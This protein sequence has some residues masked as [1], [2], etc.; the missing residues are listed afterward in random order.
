MY[1]LCEA[2]L[3]GFEVRIRCARCGREFFNRPTCP[4]CGWDPSKKSTSQGL[5][6]TLSFIRSSR[7]AGLLFSFAHSPIGLV[8]S[9]DSA[10]FVR[11]WRGD[12]CGKRKIATR[13]RRWV[14]H[15]FPDAGRAAVST[16]NGLVSAARRAAAGLRSLRSVPESLLDEILRPGVGAARPALSAFP[17]SAAA[18]EAHN[19]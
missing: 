8:L 4:W 13:V 7:S 1:F 19:Q 10:H 18:A 14:C 6:A 12:L 16:L 3:G 15:S 11:G 17:A 5:L 9:V 2:E